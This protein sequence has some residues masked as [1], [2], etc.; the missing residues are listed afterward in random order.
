MGGWWGVDDGAD[1]LTWRGEEPHKS[2]VVSAE[3]HTAA[4]DSETSIFIFVKMYLDLNFTI[5]NYH[6]SA[7]LQGNVYLRIEEKKTGKP[8]KYCSGLEYWEAM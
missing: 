7:N 5:T 8:I 2:P 1:C 6:V 4:P 3:C